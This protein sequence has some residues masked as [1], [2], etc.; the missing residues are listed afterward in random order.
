M[1]RVIIA[2][3]YAGD[4][5]RNI[6]YAREAM[7]H[8]FEQ[9]EAPFASH[10]LYPTILDDHTERDR[11]RALQAEYEWLAIADLVAFY[12]DYGWS[13]GMI[14]EL[15]VARL[16]HRKIE[17][18]HILGRPKGLEPLE[19]RNLLAYWSIT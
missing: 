19:V 13:P 16:A 7:W 17:V 2:S 6:Y 14:K 11:E 4:T 9:G 5:D 10:L 3:P 18:R 12:V 8:S 1:L 15:K